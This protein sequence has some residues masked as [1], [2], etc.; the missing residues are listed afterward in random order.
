MERQEF[1]GWVAAA[2]VLASCT[3]TDE[4]RA[5]PVDDLYAPLRKLVIADDIA[6]AMVFMP[7]RQ[8]S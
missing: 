4:T 3:P 8:P 7:L 2:P 5:K 1:L 6:P